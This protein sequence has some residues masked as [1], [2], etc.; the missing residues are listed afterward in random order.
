MHGDEK[1]GQRT[2]SGLVSHSSTSSPAETE[3]ITSNG[4]GLR[5]ALGAWPKSLET[6]WNREA[7]ERS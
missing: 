7:F 5:H 2:K 6:C 1:A 4:A 3:A